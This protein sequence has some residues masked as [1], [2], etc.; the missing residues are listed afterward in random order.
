MNIVWLAVIA[1]LESSNNACVKHPNPKIFGGTGMSRVALLDLGLKPED[2][3]CNMRAS[4]SAAWA[5]QKK[6]WS[7]TDGDPIDMAN[8]HAVGPG[9]FKRGIV[10]KKYIERF[11]ILYEAK[12]EKD[13]KD[14]IQRSASKDGTKNTRAD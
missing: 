1:F 13:I 11:R 2:V 4:K 3:H 12:S 14:R 9:A 7:L 6:Y 10:N 5:Y 8:L